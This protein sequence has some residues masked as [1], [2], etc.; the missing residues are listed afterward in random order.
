[1]IFTHPLAGLASSLEAAVVADR[2]DLHGWVV[3]R[4]PPEQKADFVAFLARGDRAAARR[5]A[6]WIARIGRDAS[7]PGNLGRVVA[8]A[9]VLAVRYHRDRKAVRTLLSAAY[10]AAYEAIDMVAAQQGTSSAALFE[11][12]FADSDAGT[13]PVT[14]YRGSHSD[15]AN[16]MRSRSLTGKRGVFWSPQLGHA[17]FYAIAQAYNVGHESG[18]PA[19]PVIATAAPQARLTYPIHKHEGVVLETIAFDMTPNL[20]DI[21]PSE[22]VAAAQQHIDNGWFEGIKARSGM[23]WERPDFEQRVSL[24]EVSTRSAASS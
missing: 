22:I 7:K 10:A 12:T 14:L 23:P 9:L 11:Y 2:G 16:A 13:A 17:A 21:S 8:P 1:M 18:E 3:A 24:S 5:L 20:L 6:I 4:S 19:R 15:L